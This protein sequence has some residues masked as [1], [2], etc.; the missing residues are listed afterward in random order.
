[1]VDI[2]STSK[3]RRSSRNCS[4][5]LAEVLAAAGASDLIVVRIAA[6]AVA[7]IFPAKPTPM[8]MGRVADLIGNVS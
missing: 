7:A 6:A 1:M 2:V 5:D 8:V 3:K 4:G